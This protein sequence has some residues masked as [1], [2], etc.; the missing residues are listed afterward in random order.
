[1]RNITII[2]LLIIAGTIKS[3]S[4]STYITVPDT[5][6][7]N[8]SVS[9][10]KRKVTY[11]FKTR[12]AVGVPGAGD[13]SGMLTMAPWIDNTGGKVH[14]MNFN[15][16]GIFYRTGTYLPN[17]WDTWRKFIVEDANG[18]V[19]IGTTDPKGYKLAVAGNMIAESMKVKLQ[20]TWPDY[21]FK[22]D[23]ELPTLEQTEKH[24]KEKGHLP[25]IPSE[26][27]VKAEGIEVGDMNAK[28]LRKI[29][30]LTLYLIEQQ[31]QIQELKKT[32]KC[33]S[34]K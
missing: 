24:I 16:G 17:Q 2:F 26:A 27:E 10:F 18:N 13:Y 11:E 33:I 15:D 34:I 4:Q 22:K 29:E 14:Q 3:Y 28:L 6:A 12:T 9:T 21:V 7:V 23:Y 20:G 30:E 32:I 31:K 8:D 25:G 1:M 5:R 19:S